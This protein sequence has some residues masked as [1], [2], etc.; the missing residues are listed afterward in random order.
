M[1]DDHTTL[2]H[3]LLQLMIAD[4]VFAV[5][6][7]TVQDDLSPKVPPF[8]ICHELVSP[9]N[10]HRAPPSIFCNRARNV[11]RFDREKAES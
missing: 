4:A 10:Q 2:H 11:Q 9:G 3:H 1:I 5:P 8:E 7:D 6:R